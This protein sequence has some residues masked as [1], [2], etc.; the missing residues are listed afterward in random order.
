MG[1]SQRKRVFSRVLPPE[2][3]LITR[4]CQKVNKHADVRIR[5]RGHTL[6]QLYIKGSVAGG[7]CGRMA[8][9]LTWLSKLGLFSGE[10]SIGGGTPLSRL[11]V[12]RGRL[13]LCRVNWDPV[14]PPVSWLALLQAIFSVNL[15]NKSL[16]EVIQCQPY[17]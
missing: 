8:K 17:Q 9:S 4:S 2:W 6:V 15:F 13:R 14:G 1:K 11:E 5:V 16:R 3:R 7:C 12:I 10:Q